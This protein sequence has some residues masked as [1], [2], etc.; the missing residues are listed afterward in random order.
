MAERP[1]PYVR[2]DPG[3]VIRS[4][5]WNELQ[6]K[7]REE[8]H[9]HR[10]SG[11]DGLKIPRDGIEANAINGE[12]IDP[13][14]KVE[15][16]SLTVNQELKVNGK[17]I[18][19]EVDD[20]LTK[21]KALE[22]E[23]INRAGD[24]IAGALNIEKELTVKGKIE[25]GDLEVT[26]TMIRKVAVA[27]GLGPGDGTDNG[28]IKSRV[29]KFNKFHADTAIRILYCD[30][31][32]LNGSGTATI[33]EIRVNGAAPPGGK[34]SQAKYSGGIALNQHEPGTILGYATGL[35]S[36]T[37]EIQI[38]VGPVPG[39]ALS[40]AHTGWPSSRWTIEAEEVRI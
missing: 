17:A 13:A 5:D 36:G 14:A 25:A 38:W 20:L 37:H 23:K 16:D 1:E 8:V 2:R 6:I 33:W 24:T 28:Q 40:D 21:F 27:T 7:T 12:L 39:H 34:I 30:N 26:G 31:F 10:H 11:A 22:T 19:S 3:D 9:A 29:L 15:L 18:L 35:A 4:G 32:R